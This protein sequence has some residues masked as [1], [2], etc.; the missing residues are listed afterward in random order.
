MQYTLQ[1]I[2]NRLAL[3]FSTFNTKPHALQNSTNKI[4]DWHIFIIRVSDQIYKKGGSVVR[5]TMQERK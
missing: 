3:S 4:I 1:V 2:M 5:A